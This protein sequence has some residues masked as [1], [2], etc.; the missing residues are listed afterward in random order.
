MIRVSTTSE[1]E[2]QEAKEKPEAP[3]NGK[4]EN[5]DDLKVHVGGEADLQGRSDQALQRPIVK[6]MKSEA[7]GVKSRGG[8]QDVF[9]WRV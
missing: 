5:P 6:M 9:D 7:N 2:K 4:M 8:I 1:I 3:K